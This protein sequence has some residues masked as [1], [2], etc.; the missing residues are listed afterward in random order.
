MKLT[1]FKRLVISYLVIIVLVICLGVYVIFQLNRL[2]GII[3]YINAVDIPTI[4]LTEELVDSLFT[5]VGF[6]E[7][8]FVAKDPD[9]Y[10]RFLEI[11]A[12]FMSNLEKLEQ[13]ADNP[14]KKAALRE[15]KDLYDLYLSMFEKVA[16]SNKNNQQQGLLYKR[17]RVEKGNIINKINQNL[18]KI[19]KIAK[20][21]R[22]EKLQKSGKISSRAVK[23]T[24]ITAFIA[25]I[26]GILISLVNTRSINTP[27]LVLQD[28]TKEIA[29][30][31][32]GPPLEI[33]SPPEIKELAD[34][35]NSMCEQLKE[36]EQ[37]KID[38][39]SHVSH[40]LRTPLTAIKEASSMLLD[41]VFI[42]R[43]EKQY[44]LFSIVKEECERLINSVNRILDL[45][46]MEAGMME[47]FFK[48]S[49]I[50]PIIE[51]SVVKL[52]PIAQKK[53]IDITL[54]LVQDLP[55]VRMDEEKIG[56]VMENLL[57]NALKFTPEGGKITISALKNTKNN[58]VEVS[59]SDTGCGIPKEELER[60]FDKFK[61]IDS[62]KRAVRGT[63]L[64]LSIAKYI[65]TAHGGQIWAESEHGRGSTF[66][67][68]LPISQ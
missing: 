9:F 67:F 15:I 17:Y 16:T 47:Y 30:G 39:I 3:H 8:Y 25:I 56:Q 34:A 51:K 61:R 31:R 12:Y 53:K 14:Q 37:M 41:G 28:K 59:V 58:T 57:S 4:R 54:N 68:S 6:E 23:A 55:I 7:K 49:S 20:S 65:I 38:F 5:Q 24:F 52:N 46:R 18:R 29:K 11:K 40:E 60:V 43:P 27:I 63:G 22:D 62:G 1:I 45:A 33:D 44:E 13:I 48:T 2:N 21:D 19:A 50:I 10:H 26:T 66:S 35:F 36:L 42:D 64:G 32:F